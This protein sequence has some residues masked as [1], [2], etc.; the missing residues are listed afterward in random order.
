[1]PWKEICPMDQKVQMIGNYLSEEYTIT[2]L[3]KMYEVSRKTIYK[4][5]R[6]YQEQGSSALKERSKAP[7]SHPNATPLEVARGIVAVKL[8]HE[9]WGPKKILAWLE[10][11]RPEE[12][13]PAVSTA[14]EIL[15]REAG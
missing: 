1:M 12:L 7:R 10:T 3:S 5:I 4:W 8:K 14:G 2:Q 9:R 15:K 13:W 6:R 11:H